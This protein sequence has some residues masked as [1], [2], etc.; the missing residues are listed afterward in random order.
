M[1]NKDKKSEN[2]N[3]RELKEKLNTLDK[4]IDE[5]SEIVDITP[6]LGL[7]DKYHDKKSEELILEDDAFSNVI[8]QVAALQFS[9][10][11]QDEICKFL[12]LSPKE[13]KTIVLTEEFQNVKKRLLEDQK[14]YILSKALEQIDGAFDKIKKLIKVADED[15][16]SLNAVA[17]LLDQISRLS[18]DIQGNF[19]GS[20]GGLA[21]KAQEE[22]ADVEVNLAQII[23]KNRKNRGLSN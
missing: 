3:L 5:K 8:E 4:F 22:G 14:T 2:D 7:I 6:E 23:M 9:G 17:L 15:K 20:L 13:F 19:A 16:T 10:K 11:K 18:N 21:K 12:D 1:S